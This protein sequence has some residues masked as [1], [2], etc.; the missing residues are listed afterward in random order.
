MF[1]TKLIFFSK[2]LYDLTNTI[3]SL[4]FLLCPFKYQF[5]TI[6]IL[7]KDFYNYICIHGKNSMMKGF[8]ERLTKEIKKFAPEDMKEEVKVIATP[9]R[10]LSVWIGGSMLN[11]FLFM[12]SK[13]VTKTKYEEMFQSF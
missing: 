7:P 8:P 5:Q 6:S 1:E 12:E 9:E 10:E 11:Q 3:L 13:W 2:D 4:L